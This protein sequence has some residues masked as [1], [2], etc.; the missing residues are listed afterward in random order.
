MVTNISQRFKAYLET[1]KDIDDLKEAKINRLGNGSFDGS[2]KRKGTTAGG[3][4]N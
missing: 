3:G 1:A 2:L 4:K